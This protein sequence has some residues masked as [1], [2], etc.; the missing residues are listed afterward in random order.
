[1]Y[2]YVC[3]DVTPVQSQLHRLVCLSMCMRLCA[4]SCVPLHVI[5]YLHNHVSVHMCVPT[6]GCLQ[7]VIAQAHGWA[8]EDIG[9]K[10]MSP[11][12]Q[13]EEQQKARHRIRVV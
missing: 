8:H 3:A 2:I 7:S 9:D 1:M 12:D 6:D 11:N 13:K 4:G 5:V 10:K